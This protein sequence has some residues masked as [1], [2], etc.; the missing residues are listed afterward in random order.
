MLQRLNDSDGTWFVFCLQLQENQD[1]IENMM[2]SVFKGIFVHRY[3]YTLSLPDRLMKRWFRIAGFKSTFYLFRDAIAE[4]RAIC[5]EEIG[6]WMKLYSDAF[7]NDSYL[8]YVGWT[9][10]DRVS[11][12]TPAQP[13][14]LVSLLALSN[15]IHLF[16]KERCVSSA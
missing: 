2:N 4:I 16:S 10:H 1:E 11:P 7:L 15:E 8:K 6:V 3:R 13:T 5:I 12:Q 9:L 14:F